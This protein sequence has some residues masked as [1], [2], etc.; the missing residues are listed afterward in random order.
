MHSDTTAYPPVDMAFA[1]LLKVLLKRKGLSGNKFATAAKTSSATVSLILSGQRSP[2]EDQENVWADALD[3]T[4]EER[5]A[6]ITAYRD[7]KALAQPRARSRLEELQAEV[8]EVRAELVSVRETARLVVKVAQKSG[9]N[10]SKDIL[11]ALG[12][13]DQIVE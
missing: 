6:F 9:V 1:D 4:G 8:N 10:F 13:E 12:L 2:P 3:L 11:E 7:A 5:A